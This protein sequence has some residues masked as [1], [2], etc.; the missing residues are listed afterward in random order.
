MAVKQLIARLLVIIMATNHLFIGG[1]VAR[2]IS[3]SFTAFAFQQ[4][5][6]AQTIEEL[7]EAGDDQS[8]LDAG[9]MVGE[10]LRGTLPVPESDGVGGYNLQMGAQT[11]TISPEGLFGPASAGTSFSNNGEY[12]DESALGTETTAK[13]TLLE[14]STTT[15][16]EA[17]RTVTDILNTAPLDLVNDPIWNASDSELAKI[18]SDDPSA[19]IN[20]SCTTTTTT[21]SNTETI[22]EYREEVCR[23]MHE[24]VG[25]C[26]VTRL[27]YI[28]V[29][30]LLGHG[31]LGTCGDGCNQIRLGP[32]PTRLG[33]LPE[34]SA[35]PSERETTSFTVEFFPNG[36]PVD[37]VSAV[38]ES[39]ST[40][41]NV[42]I[43]ANG[44]VIY[45]NS[46]PLSCSPIVSTATSIDVTSQLAS[47]VS[48]SHQVLFEVEHNAHDPFASALN[49]TYD[50]D[51][52]GTDRILQNPLNCLS[53]T[54]FPDDPNGDQGFCSAESWTCLTEDGEPQYDARFGRNVFDLRVT[55]WDSSG[56]N[57]G[58]KV[59][60]RNASTGASVELEADFD[61][62]GNP[63]N[64]LGLRELSATACETLLNHY[65][66]NPEGYNGQRTGY[67]ALL[68]GI[69]VEITSTIV[70]TDSPLDLNVR[71]CGSGGDVCYD[72]VRRD[73]GTDSI[74]VTAYPYL[75]K[76]LFPNDPNSPV[77]YSAEA[78]NYSCSPFGDADEIICLGEGDAQQCGTYEE[79][80][81]ENTCQPFKDDPLC[82]IISSVQ[83][84]A[85]L[86]PVTGEYFSSINTYQ[87]GTEHEVN[88]DETI[89]DE[90]CISD[91]KCLTGDCID[92]ADELNADFGNAVGQL[93]VANF[94][95]QENSCAGQDASTVSSCEVFGGDY[96]SCRQG[97]ALGVDCCED[98]TGASAID[99][100]KGA[101]SLMSAAN[102]AGA[103]DFMQPA[104]D[105]TYDNMTGAWNTV[106][107][108][109]GDG[110]NYVS[111]GFTSVYDSMIGTT[112]P[113]VVTKAVSTTVD[114]LGNIV[115]T[116]GETTSAI[117]ELGVGQTI[118]T[119]KNQA[120]ET[121]YNGMNS[122]YSGLGDVFIQ[123]STTNGAS[124]WGASAL[125]SNIMF[126]YMVYNLTKLA[127]SLIYACEDEEFM[128]ASQKA[129]G[130]CYKTGTVCEE[131][132]L[133]SC[134][135]DKHEYCCF[136][137]PVARIIQSQ[138]KSQFGKADDDCSGFTIE[139]L[140]QID[141]DQI[142]F[143]EWIDLLT[144]AGSIPS[145]R[146]I[147]IS[148]LSSSGNLD[149]G[150]RDSVN[151]RT[152]DK[153]DNVEVEDIRNE[154]G[155]GLR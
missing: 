134:V 13:E 109:A 17:Y 112:N 73:F 116:T 139:E 30:G 108:T 1:V 72:W 78:V 6:F 71:E 32:S 52:Y 98:P 65:I 154:L 87:C 18:E 38:F 22:T 88:S 40:A 152:Q 150:S 47:V 19:L 90:D 43:R 132:W 122:A 42:T 110:W 146:N 10:E 141:W 147:D 126:I 129:Q 44:V 93:S 153:I 128:M 138:G 143:T 68:A 2:S 58:C 28:T 155:Q 117:T 61:D 148:N 16:G 105:A 144:L 137:S 84:E 64:P 69:G 8:L 4:Y 59:E 35:N 63:D 111:E 54:G 24:T 120:L 51:W 76:Q 94:I 55:E 142:D 114:A 123:E 115:S 92:R 81:S 127:I 50:G 57:E 29:I 27:P 11:Q 53:D 12:G 149:G 99:Y 46:A 125:L 145:E 7:I 20:Q 113:N 62:D 95:K 83:D 75:H 15:D 91:I 96:A 97:S 26:D 41:G 9:E 31:E 79:L 89:V 37:I 104:V 33:D 14:T 34:C 25:S 130:M 121:A 48:A 23:D 100:I 118:E 140:G 151:D 21:V 45:S 106:Q 133:G 3:V 85:Y 135:I 80:F 67:D 101:Y 70:S 49:V 60:I 102:D 56:S 86:D 66:A 77:C 103:L 119:F 74:P 36:D 82:G 136:D 39:I 107:A 131:E 124:T 5:A